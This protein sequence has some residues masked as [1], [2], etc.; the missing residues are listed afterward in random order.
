MYD[1]RNQ[2]TVRHKSLLLLDSQNAKQP[3]TDADNLN[4]YLRAI[5]R[6]AI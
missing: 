6:T 5:N 1:R 3:F 2:R 4:N